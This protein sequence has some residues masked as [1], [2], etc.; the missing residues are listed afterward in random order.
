M[1]LP[2]PNP[3]NQ[4]IIDAW[5]SSD[6]HLMIDALA[7]TGKTTQLQYLAAEM[8]GG[9]PTLVAAFNKRNALDLESKMPPGFNCSTFN[10]LGHRAL[11]S[12]LTCRIKLDAGKIGK[13]VTALAKEQNLDLSK[14]SWKDILQLVSS[15]RNLGLVP[16]HFVALRWK[17]LAPDTWDQ[18]E[19]LAQDKY[20]DLAQDEISLARD[21]LHESCTLALK[22]TIDFDDQI[23]VSTLGRGIY[24]KYKTIMV[25]EAQDLSPLNH[26]QLKKSLARG[27]RLVI[28]GDP[29]QAIYGFRGADTQSMHSMEKMFQKAFV[30]LPLS[31]TY[32]CPRAIVA[33]QH[34]HAPDYEAA[35]GNTDGQII[36]LRDESW[37]NTSIPSPS[38]AILCRN[39]APLLGVA[40]ALVKNNLGVQIM[41]RD[42]GKSLVRLLT[43]ILG[44]KGL[45]LPLPQVTPKIQTWFDHESKLLKAN[46]KESLIAGLEDRAE[47]LY[48][49]AD[50]LAPDKTALDMITRINWLF[51]ESQ[52]RIVLATGH[53]A[54]GMEWD[55]VL[56]LDP[57][58]IPSKHAVR[59]M[60][61]GD[62]SQIIQEHNLRY[63][64]ETRSKN[65]LILANRKEFSL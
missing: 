7:G 58:R 45:D 41:G 24:T 42:I 28:V 12:A 17:T 14:E 54:K 9:P 31:L 38:F 4:A 56:I 5:L 34:D 13:L 16:E 59:A 2:T 15:A 55:T 26:L 52:G 47:C 6:S 18:W 23:Y 51:K 29:K 25:D 43:Q 44:K 36:D 37:D 33:R 60:A 61:A 39:T 62:D 53:R 46:G 10:S 22:G 30:R 50:A 11:C 19:S 8:K 32:R 20:L 49:V 63:V 64:M 40:F 21:V 57:W 3:Q 35:A 65:T 1:T 48:T 27:G